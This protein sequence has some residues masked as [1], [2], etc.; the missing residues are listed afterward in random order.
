MK[1]HWQ[2]FEPNEQQPW[3]LPRAWMLHRRAGFGA[4]WRELQRD[5]ADGLEKSVNRVLSGK[6]RDQVPKEFEA[7]SKHL[8]KRAIQSRQISR[9]SAWWILRMYLGPNALAE[10]RTLMWHNHF[11]TSN[12]SIQ[13]LLRMY[14]QNQIFRE[15]GDA[16]FGELLER[17]IKD[18]AMLVW[19]NAN[20]NRRAHPNENLGRELLEL[21][22][23][24][25]GNYT[26]KDVKEA[27][28]ALAGWTATTMMQPPADPF[29]ESYKDTMKVRTTWT[30]PFNK[31]VLGKT[32]NW[33]GDDLL[34]IVLE[35]P[36]T[37]R[38]LAWRIC[39]EVFGEGVVSDAA[40]EELAEGLVEND[41]DIQW[42]FETV[43]NSGLF[44][45]NAN[46]KSRIAPPET[47]VLGSLIAL[48]T[49][50]RPASTLA[51][52]DVLN[53]LGRSLFQPPNVGGWDGGRLWLN[54]RTLVARSNFV[55]QLVNNGMNRDA[56]HP[57]FDGLIESF[58]DSK[59]VESVVLQMCE[60][61]LGLD[62]N[63]ESGQSMA[64]AAT[65]ETIKQPAKKRW[66]FL[67]HL[68]LNSSSAQLC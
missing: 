8:L 34:K 15:Q 24:G 29:D 67:A 54:A 6:S 56:I 32:G 59:D 65:K 43:L 42:A 5:V 57:D 68:L 58:E 16:K 10:R 18:P 1:K 19:L 53:L 52:N 51:L 48:N 28:R 62:R 36:A 14:R 37:S 31:T 50:T 2:P 20:D 38:R 9:L 49:E 27:A 41:L 11:A 47:F 21:F 66:A 60:L 23:L 55:H 13:N 61:L 26:E 33:N 44:F 3:N 64:A 22:S 39:D 7:T 45:S 63:S 25:V 40:L 4:N 17:A 12:R 35:H 30:D 46:L